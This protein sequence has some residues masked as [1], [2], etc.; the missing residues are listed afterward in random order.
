MTSTVIS[1]PRE[2]SLRPQSESHT[3]ILA[4]IRNRSCVILLFS[5]HR[6]C[7]INPFFF[8]S[9][10]R[11]IPVSRGTVPAVVITISRNYKVSKYCEAYTSEI[12]IYDTS[13]E[14]LRAE[15]EGSRKLLRREN[16]KVKV[17]DALLTM[18]KLQWAQE[19][20]L[21]EWKFEAI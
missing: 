9:S 11:R 20:A 14:T 19:C 17:G 16:Q 10:K 5:L 15:A 4:H 12:K 18:G 2:L 6:R 21:M 1:D 3:H 7:R 13:I 8:F